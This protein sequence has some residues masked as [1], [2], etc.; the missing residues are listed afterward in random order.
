MRS[1][2]FRRVVFAIIDEF[3]VAHGREV[4][5]NGRECKLKEAQADVTAVVYFRKQLFI[6]AAKYGYRG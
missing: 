1:A 2:L 6:G 5:S 3:N 4:K